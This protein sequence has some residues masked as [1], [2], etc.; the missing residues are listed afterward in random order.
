MGTN[1]ECICELLLEQN[2]T[3]PFMRKEKW[4]KMNE[5]AQVMGQ[6]GLTST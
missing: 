5:S 1:N 4:F 3:K 6:T 2:E